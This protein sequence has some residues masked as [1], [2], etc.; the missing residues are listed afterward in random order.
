MENCVLVRRCC[1]GRCSVLAVLCGASQTLL[2]RLF[3]KASMGNG[4]VLEL[5][6]QPACFRHTPGLVALGLFSKLGDRKW[7]RT[8]R[9]RQTTGLVFLGL[10]GEVGDGNGYRMAM[11]IVGLVL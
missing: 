1:C 5:E 11:Q 10:F 3:D 4:H 8:A 2:H 7:Y 6:G 9:F